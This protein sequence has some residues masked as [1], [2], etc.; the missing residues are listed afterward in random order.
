M[1]VVE[2]TMRLDSNTESTGD[3]TCTLSDDDDD[4]T[5]K[6]GHRSESKE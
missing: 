3:C 1:S 4:N 5:D 6:N 2:C